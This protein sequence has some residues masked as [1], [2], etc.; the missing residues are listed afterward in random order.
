MTSTNP[1]YT[2]NIP[3]PK[4]II[5]NSQ[6][7][8]LQNFEVLYN[9]FAENHLALDAVSGAGNHTVIQLAETPKNRNYQTD[10]NEIS[11]YCRN[12]MGQTDQLF[13][14]Y[15]GNK[16]EFQFSNQQ[17]TITHTPN[18]NSTFITFF[19]GNLVVFFGTTGGTSLSLEPYPLSNICSATFC[20]VGTTPRNTPYA[21]LIGTGGKYSS[22]SIPAN[23]YYFMVV[24]N[25]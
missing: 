4:D 19:P 6:D 16:P 21:A 15:E 17:P 22:I 1:V 2:P 14:R 13:M 9:A 25:P 18:V 5:S 12:V 8:F 7:Q 3:Q 10:N 24:G 11:M 20:A 23:F